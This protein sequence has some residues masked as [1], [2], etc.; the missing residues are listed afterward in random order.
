MP[1][2]AHYCED[3]DDIVD[4]RY[5]NGRMLCSTCDRE[6]VW[7]I[8][9]IGRLKAEIKRLRAELAEKGESS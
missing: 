8:I 5:H 1:D 3:C 2:V 6:V 7:A 9:A 4:A